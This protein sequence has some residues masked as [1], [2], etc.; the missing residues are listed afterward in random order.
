MKDAVK[1]P[2]SN[3]LIVLTH[4]AKNGEIQQQRLIDHGRHEDRVWLG[5][6]CFWAFLNGKAITTIPV[7][8]RDADVPEWA[9]LC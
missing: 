8:D 7:E 5:K 6:H 9:Q 2:V 3:Y 1:R 4:N